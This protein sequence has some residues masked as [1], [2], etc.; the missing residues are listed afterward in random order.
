MTLADCEVLSKLLLIY[1]WFPRHSLL[2]YPGLEMTPLRSGL[3]ILAVTVGNSESQPRVQTLKAGVLVLL[4]NQIRS[5][6]TF[7]CTEASHEVLGRIHGAHGSIHLFLQQVWLLVTHQDH[8]VGLVTILFSAFLSEEP[9]ERLV[10]GNWG[11]T[12]LLDLDIFVPL[13]SIT[14]TLIQLALSK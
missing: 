6:M 1:C 9:S 11:K 13:R 12:C 2:I 14:E 7:L 8:R 4:K 3:P 10:C 5:S